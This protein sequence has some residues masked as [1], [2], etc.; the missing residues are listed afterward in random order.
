MYQTILE[1]IFYISSNFRVAL[2]FWHIILSDNGFKSACLIHGCTEKVF[3]GASG[4]VIKKKHGEADGRLFYWLICF[5]RE[6]LYIQSKWHQ[7][8]NLTEVDLTCFFVENIKYSS[9]DSLKADPWGRGHGRDTSWGWSR[10]ERSFIWGSS[11]LTTSLSWYFSLCLNTLG[12]G[13]TH[14]FHF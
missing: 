2:W 9:R 10:S 7:K 4:M 12:D 3:S 5:C 14:Y 13:G 8:S 6:W 11:L 1:F